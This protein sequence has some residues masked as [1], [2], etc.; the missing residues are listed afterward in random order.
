MSNQEMNIFKDEILSRIRELETKF[1]KELSKKNF[2]ININYETFSD[3]VNSILE[4]NRLMIESIT[5]QK[6]HFEKINNLELNKKEIEEKLTTHDIRINNTLNEIRKMKFNYDKVISDN[7]IIPAYIGPGSMYKSLGDFIINSVEEFKK[8]KEEK[9]KIIDANTELKSK[10]DLMSK[11]LTNFVEFNASRCIAHADSKEK[12]YQLKLEEKLREFSEKSNEINQHIY[13]NQIKLEE[14]IKEI[15]NNMIE[16]VNNIDKNKNKGE[17]NLLIFDKFEEIRKKEEEMNEKIQKAIKDVK[18]LKM[19]KKELTDELKNINLKIE[20]INKNSK[21]TFT[22]LTQQNKINQEFFNIHKKNNLNSFGNIFYST[23]N[24]VNNLNEHKNRSKKND[25][26][27]LS[28][29]NNPFVTYLEGKNNKNQVFRNEKRPS[30]FNYDSKT[31]EENKE[32]I[33]R[34]KNSQIKSNQEKKM[35]ENAFRKSTT[36]LYTDINT[37]DPEIKMTTP[38]VENNFFTPKLNNNNNNKL[39]VKEK[40]Y[41]K[42]TNNLKLNSN[43]S[44]NEIIFENEKKD[45]IRD[46]KHINIE[47]K[48][49]NI[50]KEI[51]ENEAFLKTAF[52]YYKKT[53]NNI[54]F[55]QNIIAKPFINSNKTK[56]NILI[57][58]NK[59]DNNDSFKIFRKEIINENNDKDNMINLRNSRTNIDNINA[60]ECN[61]VNLNLLELPENKKNNITSLNEYIEK[62]SDFKNQ[63]KK[64]SIKSVDSKKHIKISP[65]F[66]RTVYSFYSNYK[67]TGEIINKEK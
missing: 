63:N 30:I 38:R 66:G 61:I 39:R 19:M 1:F 21:L 16:M 55:K 15:N 67:D 65:S 32:N 54:N 13:G 35:N 6:I 53:S 3:K 44:K 34:V 50:K 57:Q 4:S 33:N 40:I 5:N 56:Q 42:S 12:D 27:N 25:L 46:K 31:E 52:D 23:N 43:G 49:K 10:I 9:E 24:N 41:E 11:N 7:L 47:F 20:E 51:I 28:N 26:P 8:F 18:E 59:N 17:V 45:D 36:N 22:Q 37:K 48:S 2:E 14:K 58:T 60:I 62:S 64:K 29:S